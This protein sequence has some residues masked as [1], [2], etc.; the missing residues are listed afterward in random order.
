MSVQDA[1]VLG[2]TRWRR[3]AA[4]AIP[5]GVLF[6]GLFAGVAAGAVP[7]A[8]NVSGQEFKVSASRLEGTGFAQYPAVV[9]KPDGTRIPVAASAIKNA[10]LT[11]LCQSVKIPGTPIVLTINAGGNGKAA[12]AE[13]LLIGLKDLR[14]D[15]TFKN[16]DIGTDA[17]TLTK[18]GSKGSSGDFGQEADSVVITDLKQ[19]AYSTHAGTFNLT[20]LSMTLNVSGKECFSDTAQQ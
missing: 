6:A 18:G 8:I 9:V 2:R 13:G 11:D 16:I 1:P 7:I 5:A 4:V 3:F 19:T 20:G 14:G 12:K 15:A 10:E 17:G